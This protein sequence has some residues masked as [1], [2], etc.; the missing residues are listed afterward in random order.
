MSSFKKK[1]SFLAKA[2]RYGIVFKILRRTFY[3]AFFNEG[4]A[5]F[6]YEGYNLRGCRAFGKFCLRGVF[7]LNG[8]RRAEKTQFLNYPVRAVVANLQA[9]SVSVFGSDS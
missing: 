1:E 4:F 3:Q 9:A 8:W 2:P 6:V 7:A 5:Q